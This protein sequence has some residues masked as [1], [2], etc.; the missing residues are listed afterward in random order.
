MEF[1]EVNSYIY[2]DARQPQTSTDY[3]RQLMIHNNNPYNSLIQNHNQSTHQLI[4]RK[5]TLSNFVNR[6][7]Q[8]SSK[9]RFVREYKR[10]AANVSDQLQQPSDPAYL[11]QDDGTN[12]S[13]S[14]Y[15]LFNL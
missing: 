12:R 6:L 3:D 15:R 14:T 10:M 13:K 2:R 9:T 8:Q 1:D 5:P 11:I 7:K 4:T